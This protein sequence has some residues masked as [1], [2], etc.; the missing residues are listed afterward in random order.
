MRIASLLAL[1]STMILA[2]GCGDSGSDPCGEGQILCDGEC[3]DACGSGEVECDCVCIPEIEPTLA[4]LQTGVFDVSCTFSGCHDSMA[5]AAG[6]DLSSFDASETNLI[7]APSTQVSGDLVVPSELEA[8]YLI[9]KLTDV[10][11]APNTTPMPQGGFPL[12]DAKLTA[13][14][15]WVLGGAPLE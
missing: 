14:E 7:N 5:P 13:V 2:L 15:L 10:D 3:I 6:L 8:S 1:A 4:D 12:C 11:I 9:N